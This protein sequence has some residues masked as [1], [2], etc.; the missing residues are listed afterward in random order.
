MSELFDSDFLNKIQKLTL[1]TGIIV[2]G[3]AGGNRKSRQKGSS[4]EF[5]DYREYSE[6]DDFRRIDWNAYGRFEKLYV[7]LFMEEREAPV[8]IFLDTSKS[9]DWGEPNKSF[10]SRRLA[11]ALGY[12]SLSAYDRVSVICLSDRVEKSRLS[13]RG[14][15]F[16]PELLTFLEEVEY[17]NGPGFYEAIK[18]YN[19]KDNRGISII[20]SDLFSPGGLTEMIKY[21]QY[22]KQDVYICQIL[23]PWEARPDIG[24][25]MRLVDSETGR[26]IDVTATP[27]LLKSYNRIFNDFIANIREE[28]FRKGAAYYMMDTAMPIEQMISMI[29]GLNKVRS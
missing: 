8:N 9:M 13:L 24:T 20:I 5:S 18:A 17:K 10:A 29:T 11:A 21:L 23:A 12:M 6:G 1:S 14:K 22:R 16:L 27:R 19:L 2:S 26:T 7:K 3:G 4:V 28:C 25:N 15:H